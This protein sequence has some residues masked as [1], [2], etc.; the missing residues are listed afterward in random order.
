MA[1]K[2]GRAKKIFSYKENPTSRLVYRKHRTFRVFFLHLPRRRIYLRKISYFCE[3]LFVCEK[4]FYRKSVNK[5]ASR[6][7]AS[8]FI[9]LFQK[10]LRAKEIV[11]RYQNPFR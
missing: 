10:K 5:K 8:F 7:K 11:F 4:F 9:Y 3:K 6:P 2:G 1:L